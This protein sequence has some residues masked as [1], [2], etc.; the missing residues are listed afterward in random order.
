[1]Q[2]NSALIYLC[3]EESQNYQLT[4]NLDIQLLNYAQILA[5]S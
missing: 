4:Y 5:L 1:M 2:Q 3:M